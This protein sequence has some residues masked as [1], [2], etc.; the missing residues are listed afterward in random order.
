VDLG[1][2]AADAERVVGIVLARAGR[3]AQ[4][5]P[6]LLQARARGTAADP[7]V[8]G[9]LT[10]IYFDTDRFHLALKSIARWA[11]AAPDDPDPWR[12]RAEFDV[13][14]RKHPRDLVEDYRAILRRAPD[15]A[16]A[17]LNLAETLRNS[18]RLAESRASYAEYLATRPDDPDALAGAG[19]TALAHGL[20][21]EARGF[22]DRALAVDPR[23]PL[24]LQARAALHLRHREWAEALPLLDRA[25]E[26][27]PDNPDVH[28]ERARA[29]ERLGQDDEARESVERGNRIRAEADTLG[30][31]RQNLT[32]SPGQAEVMAEAASWMLAHGHEEEG[33]LWARRALETP[34]GHPA[35]ARVLADYFERKGDAA[36]AN[37][38]R[39]LAEPLKP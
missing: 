1:F 16:R 25:A 2:P 10:R 19:K 21:V 20:E 31:L 32:L 35:T 28:F 13:R 6:L 34:G 9:A 4:A 18:G 39:L 22:L 37:Y 12:F 30:V 24:A 23:H 5:E 3:F 14:L 17:R 33:L 26:L 36:Q 27:A 15:D 38:Y 11:E 8:E 29:L 7:E